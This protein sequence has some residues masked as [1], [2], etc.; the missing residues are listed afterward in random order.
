MP[1]KTG[2]QADHGVTALRKMTNRE[3]NIPQL[4]SIPAP[5]GKEIGGRGP[6]P[7]ICPQKIHQAFSLR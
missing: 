7:D 4:D 3:R 2:L 6:W 5:P 1:A